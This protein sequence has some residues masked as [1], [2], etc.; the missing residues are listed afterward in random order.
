VLLSSLIN[1]LNKWLSHKHNFS[2]RAKWQ[3]K[4]KEGSN[5]DPPTSIANS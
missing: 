2:G 3:E 1:G 5:K 4:E